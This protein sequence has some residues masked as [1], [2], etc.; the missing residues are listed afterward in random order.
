MNTAGGLHLWG[1]GCWTK[2]SLTVFET[3]L[4]KG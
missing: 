2:A 3:D 4:G 1:E